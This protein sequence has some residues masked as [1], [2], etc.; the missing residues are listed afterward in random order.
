M[1]RVF[2][3]FPDKA[4]GLV[5]VGAEDVFLHTSALH[6]HTDGIVGQRVVVKIIEDRSRVG[7]AF[8]ATAAKRE[9]DFLE[10][11]TRDK[12]MKA[13]AAAVRA[14][15]EAKK[16]AMATQAALQAA[17]SATMRATWSRPPGLA[18][19]PEQLV[20]ETSAVTVM[21]TEIEQ[22][23]E[24]AALAEPGVTFMGRSKQDSGVKIGK[25][26]GKSMNKDSLIEIAIALKVEQN[27]KASGL[28]ALWALR[29]RCGCAIWR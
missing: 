18:R 11:Q 4:F 13:A 29:E 28:S 12:A 6:G 15:E 19:C 22:K 8:R 5:R 27:G 26:K 10:E 1:G 24:V 14:S 17:E 7:G 23:V 16:R 2:R 9:A 20:G 21:T 25:D 3:W